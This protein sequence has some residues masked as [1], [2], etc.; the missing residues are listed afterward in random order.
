MRTT[1]TVAWRR[2][3]I[4][5][6]ICSLAGAQACSS[7]GG[8]PSETGGDSGEDT[9]GKGGSST[10]GKGGSGTGGK[11]STGGSMGSPDAGP[12]GGSGG[13]GGSGGS[14]TGGKGTGGS[15]T[16]GKGSGGSGGSTGGAGGSTGGA[17]GGGGVMVPAGAKKIAAHV[18]TFYSFQDNTPVNSLFSASG[19]LPKQYSSVAVPRRELK[20]NGGTLNFGDKLWLQFLAG[21]TMPNGTKHTGWVQVDDFCGDGSDDT[22]CY[23]QIDGKGP[24]YPNVDL[25]IG[26]FSKSGF[27]PVPPSPDHPNGDCTGPSGSG[28]D[29]T[30]TYTGTP[31][32]FETNYGGAQLGTGKCG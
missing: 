26:D 27:M 15:G 30:D 5:L 21:R 16:G 14:G 19:R 25:Y 17:G 11:S 13:D 6:A 7:G 2:T 4:S 12:E 23:Q 3:L 32:T 20:A 29:L 9:G 28:Q 8:H 18:I 10:G 24:M 31:A 1:A 22:Y